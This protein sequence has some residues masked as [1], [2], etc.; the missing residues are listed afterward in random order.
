MS[1][2]TVTL[3]WSNPSNA[4]GD[5]VYRDG[6]KIA[7]PGW[8]NPVVTSFQDAG[9]GAGTHSYYV[10]AYDG[11]GEGPAS[12]VVTVTVGSTVTAPAS[13]PITTSPPVAPTGL[14]AT[15]SGTTV[16][17]KWSNPSSAQGNNI[18]RDGVKI[19]W[20]GWPN[21]VVTS[22]VDTSPGT[23]KHSYY[24]T[25]YDGNGAGP[26]SNVVTVTVATTVTKHHH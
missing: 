3:N 22:F 24:V 15:V 9:L 2:T 8:P 13:P 25:A 18:Y 1:G 5:D 21:P 6:V 14:T 26:G 4:Q 7:W 10:T 16:T 17:L 19:A 23:G 12:N 11:N 20:P